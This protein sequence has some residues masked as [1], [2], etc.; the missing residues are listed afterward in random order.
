VAGL[1][2]VGSMIGGFLGGRYARR[3]SPAALRAIIVAIGVI[4]IARLVA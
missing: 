1:I 3:L 4:A 2:A